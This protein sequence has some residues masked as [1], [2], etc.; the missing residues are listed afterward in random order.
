MG[1]CILFFWKESQETMPFTFGERKWDGK[2]RSK[3]LPFSFCIFS[4]I[5]LK[6]L[7]NFYF[8]YIFF[9]NI[10]KKTWHSTVCDE[11]MVV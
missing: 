3:I 10:K 6:D 9:F 1:T 4:G 5:K 7:T 11:M 8:G 2:E